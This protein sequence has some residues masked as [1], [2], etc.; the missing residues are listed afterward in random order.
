MITNLFFRDLEAIFA[1]INVERVANAKN[2]IH[3]VYDKEAILWKQVQ[4]VKQKRYP[5][6]IIILPL[7]FVEKTAHTQEVTLNGYMITSG[8]ST[9]YANKAQKSFEDVLYP[10]V[11]QLTTALQEVSLSSFNQRT[12]RELPNW[13]IKEEKGGSDGDYVNALSLSMTYLMASLVSDPSLNL[14]CK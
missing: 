2:P 13:L 9:N 8:L 10:A 6:F 7:T 3:L 1:R 12:I 5:A 11:N 4:A 14:G